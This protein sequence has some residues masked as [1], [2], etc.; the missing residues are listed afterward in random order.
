MVVTS[1][2]TDLYDIVY[3]LKDCIGVK[4]KTAD[5]F[6]KLKIYLFVESKFSFISINRKKNY[7]KFVLIVSGFLVYS[8]Y[9]TNKTDRHD[10]TDILLKVA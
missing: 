5:H 3:N 9:L 2:Q 1:S 6:L 4:N 8:G 10:I 7:N